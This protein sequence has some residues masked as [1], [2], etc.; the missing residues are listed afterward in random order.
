MLTSVCQKLIIF[1]SLYRS[2]ISSTIISKREL[3][4]PRTVLGEVLSFKAN[5]A[6][7][8]YDEDYKSTHQVPFRDL[9]TLTEIPDFET[10]GFTYVTKRH[11]EGIETLKQL[12]DQH[13]AAL[14]ADSV[15]LVK[16]LTGATSAVSYSNQFRHHTKR[17][18]S[19]TLP[20]IHSDLSTAGAKF[21]K[22]HLQER[23]LKSEDPIEQEFGEHLS[24]GGEDVVI[25]NV[26]RP[27]QK[28]KDNP[29]GLCKWDSVSKEDQLNWKIRPDRQSNSIQ[30][31][32]Y[33]P[34]QQWFYLSEQEPHEVYVFIQH[35][36]RA[37]DGHGISV[38]HASF[39]FEED[40]K[41]QP[42]R[43]SFESRIIAIVPK[44][45]N[46]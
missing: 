3:K 37:E 32:D 45:D 24:R 6:Y 40:Y 21:M 44:K 41:N 10:Y 39:R 27:I 1:I 17:F 34:T 4:D 19:Q 7:N 11:V 16:D 2:F 31:W 38:P 43:M 13:G 12:S 22:G 8:F 33:K 36:S 42:K 14:K 5:E 18:S 30:V 28:V 26:W 9:R 29:L 35:D 15:K 25:F 46:N 23:F 20:M